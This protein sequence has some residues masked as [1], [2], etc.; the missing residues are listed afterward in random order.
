MSI[1]CLEGASAVGKTTVSRLL[2]KEFGFVHIAEVNQLFQRPNN[3]PSTW[4][5][6]RQVER[7]QWAHA[8]SQQGGA[9]VLDGDPFQPLWYNWI[10]NEDEHLQP[11]ADVFDFYQQSLLAGDIE[12]PHQYFVLETTYAELKARKDSDLTRSRSGFDKHLRLIE[13]QKTYFKAI[14]HRGLSSVSFLESDDPHRVAQK[15]LSQP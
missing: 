3:E 7:W 10:F 6:E 12:F 4:Y 11:L 5:F 1:I 13:P 15:I 2:E 14:H 9:A 8:V